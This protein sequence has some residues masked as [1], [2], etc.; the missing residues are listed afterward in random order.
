[1]NG[2]E[3]WSK[4]EQKEEQLDLSLESPQESE[5][6]EHLLFLVNKRPVSSLKI[7]QEKYLSM[8]KVF[9]RAPIIKEALLKRAEDEFYHH[10]F[11]QGRALII[12]G[13]LEDKEDEIFNKVFSQRI[14][15][16]DP[17]SSKLSL[18]VTALIKF[19][20]TKERKL[21]VSTENRINIKNY[22][23]K[24]GSLIMDNFISEGSKKITT[25]F[26]QFMS[27]CVKTEAK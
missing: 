9:L 13:S 8:S 1:M 25:E 27:D 2:N 16:A 23:E 11:E 5:T 12:F 20:S 22:M 17:K 10:S 21:I 15:E 7:F 6:L 3:R 4:E 19:N 14:H 24:N 18:F 26:M